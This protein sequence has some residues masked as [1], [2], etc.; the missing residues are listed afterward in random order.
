MKKL[1][2]SGREAAI[3]RVIDFTTG[4]PGAEIM[5]RTCIDSDELLDILNGLLDVGYIETNPIT[6][7]VS[8]DHLLDTIFEV[9]PAYAHDL[10]GAIAR[11]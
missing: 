5:E 9:N 1:K 7:R 2:F 3:L 10:R 4:T 11:R 6:E 8:L